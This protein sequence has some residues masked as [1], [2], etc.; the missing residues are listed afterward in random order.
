MRGPGLQKEGR[1]ASN[2]SSLN[3]PFGRRSRMASQPHRPPDFGPLI[4]YLKETNQLQRC[5]EAI[6]IKRIVE[7]VGIEQVMKVVGINPVIEGLQ[8]AELSSALPPTR[9]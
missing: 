3:R 1:V 9:P 4:D 8:L 7:A 5:L 2:C 6:G